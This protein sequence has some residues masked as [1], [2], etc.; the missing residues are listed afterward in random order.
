MN[1]DR[2]VDGAG[3]LISRSVQPGLSMFT[4]WNGF[5]QL[6][7]IDD[8]IRSG[9]QMI[10]RRQ[11]GYTAQFSPSRLAVDRGRERHLR[12]AD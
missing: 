1:L 11:V 10:G 5:V 6:R 7:Y 12:T 8:D 4:R 3:D 9:G 2:Q